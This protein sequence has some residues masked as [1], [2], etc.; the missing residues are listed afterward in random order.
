V[1]SV[2]NRDGVILE[3]HLAS[4]LATRLIASAATADQ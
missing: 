2:A 4:A 1:L 3:T